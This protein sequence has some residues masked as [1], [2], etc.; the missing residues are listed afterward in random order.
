MENIITQAVNKI[1]EFKGRNIGFKITNKSMRCKN[2]KFK[3]NTKHTAEIDLT[4]KGLFLYRT[5]LECLSYNNL[6][7][8]KRL[9]IVEYGNNYIFEADTIIT[10]ELTF[11]REITIDELIQYIEDN[12]N[13]FNSYNSIISSSIPLTE[14]FIEKHED[15][16][17]W[18]MISISQKLSEAFIEKHHNKVNWGNIL[19]CQKLSEEF[20]EKY[21]N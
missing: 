15:K 7:K 20:I 13:L 4:E 1:G 8:D 11:L 16:V 17:F 12:I 19:R 10:D 9:F 3:L 2:Y 14:A 21:S 6:L 18:Y 5:P